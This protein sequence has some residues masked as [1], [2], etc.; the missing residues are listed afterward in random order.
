MKLNKKGG[1]TLIEILTVIVILGVLAGLAVPVYV[2]QV[3]RSYRAEALSHLASIRSA[4]TDFYSA[5]GTY[6]GA[7]FGNPP[8]SPTSIGY[9]DPALQGG[10]Q[11]Q[12]FT[13]SLGTPAAGTYTV[14]A[15]GVAVAPLTTADT[16]TITQAGEIGGSL[17]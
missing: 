14:T 2:N 4:M 6:V 9:V 8:I 1:F 7:A 11:T 5:N 10:G 13:Y 15:T 12:H 17:T 3:K 16:V